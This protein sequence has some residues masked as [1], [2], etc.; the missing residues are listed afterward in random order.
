MLP[1]KWALSHGRKDGACMARLKGLSSILSHRVHGD[2][3]RG[4]IR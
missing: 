2:D 3:A 4:T 1:G